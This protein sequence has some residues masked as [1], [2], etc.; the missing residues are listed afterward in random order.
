VLKSI[1]K[2]ESEESSRSVCSADLDVSLGKEQLYR[3]K[4][5]ILMFEITII[6]IMLIQLYWIMM[7][8][9]MFFFMQIYNFYE[10]KQEAT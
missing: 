5:T 4:I 2:K 6:E 8:N 7:K 3:R 1:N 9:Y 10:K